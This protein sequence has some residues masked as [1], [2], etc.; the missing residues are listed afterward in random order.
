M[1]IKEK[2]K[3][4]KEQHEEVI[5]YAGM[6]LG[7]GMVFAGGYMVGYAKTAQIV[8]IG[9]GYCCVKDPTLKTHLMDTI[10][11]VNNDLTTK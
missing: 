8:D 3:D 7:L 5:A 4:F 11:A 10:A 9:L 2:I 1:K 6:V